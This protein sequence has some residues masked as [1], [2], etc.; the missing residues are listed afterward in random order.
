MLSR[1]FFEHLGTCTVYIMDVLGK[2]ETTFKGAVLSIPA[3]VAWCT[4]CK[5]LCVLLPASAFQTYR[6]CSVESLSSWLS[7]EC[8]SETFAGQT[9]CLAIGSQLICQEGTFRKSQC[10]YKCFFGQC[11]FYDDPRGCVTSCDHSSKLASQLSAVPGGLMY[12]SLCLL[13]LPLIPVFSW[14]IPQFY[15]VIP[16]PID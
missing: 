5:S 15:S 2:P 11:A 8:V 7:W 4:C 13:V 6:A 10:L 12:M 16:Q 1:T 9:N 14:I 3:K